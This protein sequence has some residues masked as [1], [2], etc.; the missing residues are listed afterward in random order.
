MV[1]M[2]SGVLAAVVLSA[3][4]TTPQSPQERILGPWSCSLDMSGLKG[5]ANLT[6]APGGTSSGPISF[7]GEAEGIEVDITGDVEASW[8]FLADGKLR[9]SI[10]DFSIKTASFDGEVMSPAMIAGMIEPMLAETITGGESIA[11]VT[12]EGNTMTLTG[13]GADPTLC[14]R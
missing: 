14:T 11:E 4:A 13:D 8:E 10:T 6:Y 2:I 3:C 12:F 7:S 5:S 9:E 1:R